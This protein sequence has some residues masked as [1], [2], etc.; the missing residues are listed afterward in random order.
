MDLLDSRLR[1]HPD[2]MSGLSARIGMVL[3]SAVFVE[4]EASKHSNNMLLFRWNAVANSLLDFDPDAGAKLAVRCIASFANVNSVTAG[5]QPEPLKFMSN[6][7]KAKPTVVWPAIAR[8]LEMQRKEI[9]TWHL[10]NWL[11]GGRSMCGDDEAGLGAIPAP[12]VF[13]WVD[14]DA[15]DRA[16]LLAEHCPPIISRP[17]DPATFARQMLERYGAMEQVRRCLHA[18]NFTE[19]WSGPASEHYRRKLENL[20]A[21]LEVETNDNVRMWLDEHREQLEH[22]IERETEQE[23]RESE[24]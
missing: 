12:V 4:G 24:H 20:N 11:R 13:E 1:G 8:R 16:W 5:F 21:H 9:G 19:S 6:A 14:I 23:L 3:N 18:N 15:V 7:A 22:S 17:D 10:L 2:E